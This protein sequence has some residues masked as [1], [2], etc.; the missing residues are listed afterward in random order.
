MRDSFGAA[1]TGSEES[2]SCVVHGQSVDQLPGCG[3]HG[4]P[5]KQREGEGSVVRGDVE[6]EGGVDADQQA[7][8]L[9]GQP[10]Q[11]HRLDQRPG[12]LQHLGREGRGLSRGDVPSSLVRNLNGHLFRQHGG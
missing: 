10:L 2:S 8:G 12:R 1:R 6:L 3:A 9:D 7:D 11:P 4:P 5:L